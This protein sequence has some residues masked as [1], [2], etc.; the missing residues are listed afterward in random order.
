MGEPLKGGSAPIG[1]HVSDANLTNFA[2]KDAQPRPPRTGQP[3]PNLPTLAACHV[4]SKIAAAQHVW[5]QG[6]AG[7]QDLPVW[8]NA[9]EKTRIQA[10]AL[11]MWGQAMPPGDQ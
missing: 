9:E 3:G 6:G 7:S 8:L 2:P 5:A 11:A 4:P 10:M 1:A